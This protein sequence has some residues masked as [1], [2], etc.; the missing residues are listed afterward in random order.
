MGDRWAGEAPPDEAYSRVTRDL[1]EVMA[2]FGL[3]LDELPDRL[4]RAYVCR[5]REPHDQ[6]IE[7][8]RAT[9]PWLEPEAFTAYAVD[10]LDASRA[11]LLVR[12][13]KDEE[14]AGA[15]VAF[16]LVSHV[17]VPDCL[18]DACDE[19]SDSAIEQ[20]EEFI[21]V[22]TGGCTEF[23]RVKQFGRMPS[24]AA[25]LTRPW[26]EEGYRS[27]TS[28]SSH[29]SAEVRGDVFERAWLP[30]LTRPSAG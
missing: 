25:P 20:V 17:D 19:D 14:S 5:V 28:A 4:E 11:T 7:R 2:A 10:P 29:A 23:R 26:L 22:A 24:W 8:L 12:R 1:A 3:Y 18:C 21:G 27:P 16:G 15:L 6:E 9:R 13:A 30:W